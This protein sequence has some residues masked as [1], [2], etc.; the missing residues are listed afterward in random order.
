MESFITTTHKI[1]AATLGIISVWPTQPFGPRP[2]LKGKKIF[3]KEQPVMVKKQIFGIHIEV[4]I[5]ITSLAK[6]V[7]EK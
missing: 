5:H 1:L 7:T 4:Y 3:Q 6:K 2:P